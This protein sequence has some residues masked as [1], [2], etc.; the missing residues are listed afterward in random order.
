MSGAKLN[1]R[2]VVEVGVVAGT[3]VKVA[4]VVI[5][6]IVK[7]RRS[8]LFVFARL[9]YF[10][11]RGSISSDRFASKNKFGH[12]YGHIFGTQLVS[13]YC[14]G[15]HLTTASSLSK[16]SSIRRKRKI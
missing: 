16:K 13:L 5:V 2:G 15:G 4:V 9:S 1:P 11:F 8:K 14:D 6:D 3:C 10:F 7:S 12:L